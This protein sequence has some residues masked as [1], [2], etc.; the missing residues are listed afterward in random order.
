VIVCGQ[1]KLDHGQITLEQLLALQDIATG[2]AE[3][4]LALL[5]F[6]FQTPVQE[7][8]YLS[9][10]LNG[11]MALDPWDIPTVLAFWDAHRG[12]TPVVKGQ[13]TGF[14]NGGTHGVVVELGEFDREGRFVEIKHATIGDEVANLCQNG[15]TMTALNTFALPLT[16]GNIVSVHNG[17][18]A[19]VW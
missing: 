3:P 18:I 7:L 17:H 12:A 8:C 1:H 2:R 19:Y 11:S 4:N 6:C 10:P 9:L 15:T 13:V 16:V 14:R 5:Y